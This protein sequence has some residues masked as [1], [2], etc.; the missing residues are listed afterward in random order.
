MIDDIRCREWEKRND[1]VP[2]YESGSESHGT[3]G[4][5]REHE[6]RHDNM[7]MNEEGYEDSYRRAKSDEP[8][9]LLQRNTP[10]LSM[11]V[12]GVHDIAQA[13]ISCDV[14]CSEH[15]SH[16]RKRDDSTCGDAQREAEWS[17]RQSVC[18]RRYRLTLG[19]PQL[20]IRTWYICALWT[21]HIMF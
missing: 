19:A 15:R 8:Q 2:S 13:Q 21:S 7:Q 5:D 14:I 18:S 11:E 12:R 10:G 3:R 6:D 20:R 16:K 1:L 4:L 9:V 17:R